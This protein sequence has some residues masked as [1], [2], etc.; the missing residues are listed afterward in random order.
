MRLRQAFIGAIFLIFI[1]AI[2]A[3][4]QDGQA[5]PG[6]NDLTAE[7]L[8]LMAGLAALLGAALTDA[9]KRLPFLA[10]GDKSKLSGPL[11]QLVSVVINIAAGYLVALAGQ[12]LGL[13]DDAGL[14]TLMVTI[15]APVLAEIRY[16]LVKLAPV[17]GK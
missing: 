14:R 4:A 17:E 2:P 8:A 1:F 9:I 5:T 3:L 10:E 16:R 7:I 12:G 11:A 15:G 6:P 13:I